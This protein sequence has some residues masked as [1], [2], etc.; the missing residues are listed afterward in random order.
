MEI[1]IV[2]RTL[3]PYTGSEMPELICEKGS[4]TDFE[5]F[6][7]YLKF[8]VIAIECKLFQIKLVADI[9]CCAKQSQL[10]Q[11]MF[12]TNRLVRIL[13]SVIET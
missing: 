4:I 10:I 12:S 2:K 3:K 7:E 11:F 8:E 9:Q 13:I 5:E 6:I 1:Q